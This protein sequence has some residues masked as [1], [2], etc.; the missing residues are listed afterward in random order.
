MDK[1]I[2]LC[3][4]LEKK[5]ELFTEYEKETLELI[6][7]EPEGMEHYIIRRTELANEI[8]GVTEEIG[9]ACDADPNAKLLYETASAQIPYSQVPPEWRP[10]FERAQNMFSVISRIQQS[11]SQ[12]VERMEGIRKDAKERIKQNQH[13]PKIKKYLTDLSSKPEEG[14]YR[15]GKA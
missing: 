8:D 15:S 13:M 11:D 2:Q 9:K 10:V 3:T 14:S 4:L 5:I 1:I 12:I 7:C 6:K